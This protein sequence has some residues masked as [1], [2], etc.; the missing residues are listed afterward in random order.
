MTKENPT[1]EQ[2]KEVRQQTGL[3]QTDSAKLIH[4]SLRSWQEWEQ[5]YSQMHTGLYE[6]FLL[7]T[8]QA[9]KPE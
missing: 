1:K 6:L 2:V 5:G 3:T 4:S 8:G 7:K 9:F